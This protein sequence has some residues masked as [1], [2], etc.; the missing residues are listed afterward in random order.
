MD[1]NLIF[2]LLGLI[3][4]AIS[5]SLGVYSIRLAKKQKMVL[6]TSSPNGHSRKLLSLFIL[7]IG[8][9]NAFF[10]FGLVFVNYIQLTQ[11]AD[12]SIFYRIIIIDWHPVVFFVFSI[13]AIQI[14]AVLY[15][16]KNFKKN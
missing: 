10:F 16:I 6:Q 9:V 11:P 14:L 3:L 1:Y 13:L 7:M 8:L 2:T 12:P 5:V 4:G 15:L